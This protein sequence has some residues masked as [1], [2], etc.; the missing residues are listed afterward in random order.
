[1]TKGL[2]TLRRVFIWFSF[3]V[4]LVA[5]V[6]CRV[7]NPLYGRRADSGAGADG[8]PS[9]GGE[10]V[11]GRQPDADPRDN[12]PS[13]DGR[14]DPALDAGKDSTSRDTSQPDLG[15]DSQV[16][17]AAPD[18]RNADTGPMSCAEGERRLCAMESATTAA[19]SC[20]VG[21][22]SCEG[23][24]WTPCL[25]IEQA[26]CGL[27]TCMSRTSI[28]PDSGRLTCA[29]LSPG[30]DSDPCGKGDEDCDGLVDED[31]LDRC[32]HVEPDGTDS[33][34]DGTTAKPFRTIQAAVDWAAADASR[35]K[36][37]CVAGAE[38]CSAPEK[39]AYQAYQEALKIPTKVSVQGGYAYNPWRSCSQD[40]PTRLVV[41][42]EAGVTFTGA[43][44][45]D[46]SEFS[47]FAITR[48][49]GAGLDTVAAITVSGSKT[50]VMITNVF[51]NDSP[52][53]KNTY[54]VRVLDGADAQIF[55]SSI[56]S[57]N[58][59]QFASAVQVDTGKIEMRENC[60]QLNS[61]GSCASSCTPVTS[62]MSLG[63][64]GPSA[65]SIVA[66]SRVEVVA[67][68]NVAAPSMVAANTV[69]GAGADHVVGLH[70]DSAGGLMVR[71]N[72]IEVSGGAKDVDGV[73][74]EGCGGESPRLTDNAVIKAQSPSATSRAHAIR[75]DGGCPFI[76]SNKSI[77]VQPAADGGEAYG[78]RCYGG[79]G[80]RI[81]GNRSIVVAGSKSTA[82]VA[83]VQ[84][85]DVDSCPLVS[86]NV[87][88]RGGQGKTTS[89]ISLSLADGLVSDNTVSGGCGT[90]SA[91]AIRTVQS[92]TQLVGNTTTNENCPAANMSPALG[93]PG[94]K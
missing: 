58:G 30:G 47:R 22:Q 35:F 33:S 32:V 53:A 64:R 52:V 4:V 51:I 5:S 79:K 54:G 28:C 66:D 61:D 83:A 37:V 18:T 34:A 86:H 27:G 12:R 60:D 45:L 8:D 70:I 10:D 43:S 41:T 15:K 92:T 68:T 23:S 9:G 77:S 19:N 49:S 82:V 90:A 59:S 65:P 63:L 62:T 73:F 93:S 50:A 24:K 84:C 71:A 67:L 36:R 75:S 1:M 44:A 69:C 21:S 31:C 40:Q 16:D 39:L 20:Q 29:P 80:C 26:I 13:A 3:C 38:T 81:L 55:R 14:G 46:R 17:T 89:G 94:T 7:P 2:S 78:I 87:D 74:V 91:V 76:D 25:G 72:H 85:E 57:G 11:T 42:S 56:A 6:G 88:I 48:K